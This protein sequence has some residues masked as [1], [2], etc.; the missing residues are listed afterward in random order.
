MRTGIGLIAEERNRQI[1]CEG[2]SPLHD[3]GHINSE[4]AL[5]GA[6][7]ALLSAGRITEARFIYPFDGMQFVRGTN[8]SPKQ[9]LVQAAA[10]IAA[11]I[12]R[13]QRGEEG[14]KG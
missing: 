5:A 8:K 11:E 2:Y 7:F 9:L 1:E 6:A 13:L 4:L 14:R 12:D 10:L 3:D